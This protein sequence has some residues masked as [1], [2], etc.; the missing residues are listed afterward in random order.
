MDWASLMSGGARHDWVDGALVLGLFWAALVHPDRI[1]SVA[2]LRLSALL[3]GLAIAAPALVQQLLL[4]WPR[5][6]LPSQQAF[7][8]GIG[9]LLSAAAV[10]LGVGSVTPRAPTTRA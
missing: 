8:L 10:I 6:L 7:A 1:Q 2:K 4:L 5:D 9:P 3:V